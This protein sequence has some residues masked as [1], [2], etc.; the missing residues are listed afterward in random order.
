MNTATTRCGACWTP[1]GPGHPAGFDR[2]EA[3]TRHSRS[4]VRGPNP[5]E[6]PGRQ[7]L[8]LRIVRMRVFP[9]R[10]GPARFPGMASFD[11]GCRRRPTTTAP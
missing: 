10:V 1:S 2:R 7:R 11:P 5:P 9:L 8:V 4:L 6:N 3:E